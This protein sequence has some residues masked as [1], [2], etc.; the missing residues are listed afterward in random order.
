MSIAENIKYLRKQKK[1][2]QRELAE[3]SGLAII[4]IQGY[5]SGKYEPKME[6]IYKLRKALDCNIYEILDKPDELRDHIDIIINN[7]DDLDYLPEKLQE[8]KENL[9]HDETE[10][11]I[12]LFQLLNNNGKKKAIEQVELLTKI[13]AYK[14]NIDISKDFYFKIDNDGNL[15]KVNKPI[16]KQEKNALTSEENTNNSEE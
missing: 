12:E 7:L 11:L 6:S 4:T 9:L 8:L 15:V 3:K 10:K 1:M 13:P 2:T 16:Q 5:E 14:A